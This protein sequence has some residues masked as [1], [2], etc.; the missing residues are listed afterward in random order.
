MNDNGVFLDSDLGDIIATG[1]LSAAGTNVPNPQ[2]AI[3]GNQTLLEVISA[4]A[5]GAEL[6]DYRKKD[7]LTVYDSTT[8]QQTDD[9]LTTKQ[10]ADAI[11]AAIP[12]TWIGT[13][14]EYDMLSEKDPSTIY[15]IKES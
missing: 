9:V 11:S 7:D 5:P 1:I 2:A 4:Y 14:D 13:Q 6:A 3:F 15:F 10:Y 8:H 12:K